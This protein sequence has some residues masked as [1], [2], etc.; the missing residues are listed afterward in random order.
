VHDDVVKTKRDLDRWI[1][2]ALDFNANAK[3]SPKRS[4][5]RNDL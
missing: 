2:L 4:R 5:K 1:K 3:A